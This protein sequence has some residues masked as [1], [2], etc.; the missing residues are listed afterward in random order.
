MS[1]LKPV[2][3]KVNYFLLTGEIVFINPADDAPTPYAIRLNTLLTSP[4]GNITEMLIGRAQQSLQLQFFNGREPTLQ[5]QDVVILTVAP[6]GRMTAEEF[7]KRPEG[8]VMTEQKPPEPEA[9][10]N[11]QDLSDPPVAPVPAPANPFDN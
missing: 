6:L 2:Q 1:A 11:E 8:M 7:H 9:P 5:V 10:A 4:D 3:K